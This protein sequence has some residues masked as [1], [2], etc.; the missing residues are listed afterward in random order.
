MESHPQ[1]AHMNRIAIYASFILYGKRHSD[2]LSDLSFYVTYSA[3]WRAWQDSG[4]YDESTSPKTIRGKVRSKL[5]EDNTKYYIRN[6]PE[7]ARLQS[8]PISSNE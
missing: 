2:Y 5:I 1:G 3:C 6:I 8:A 7:T 4:L